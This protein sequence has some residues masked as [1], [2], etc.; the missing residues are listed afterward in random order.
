MIDATIRWSLYIAS[1]V[2][3]GPLAGLLMDLTDGPDGSAGTVLVSASPV[4]GALS[5]LLGSLLAA[6]IG[7]LAGW[8]SGFRP[9]LTCAGIVVCWMAGM[10][11]GITPAIAAADGGPWM[12]FIL[13]GVLVGACLLGMGVAVALAARHHTPAPG[14]HVTAQSS[15]AMRTELDLAFTPKTVATVVLGAAVG[16]G[17]AWVLA[18]TDL[19]GQV[20]AASAIAAVAVGVL[21]KLVD[22]RTPALAALAALALLG[23]AGPAYAMATISGDDALLAAY[24]QALP[25]IVR[26]TPLDWAAGALLGTPLGLAWAASIVKRA[27]HEPP[28][29]L[30]A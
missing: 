23:V 15:E 28:R 4:L 21:I 27:E 7:A 1:L 12:A 10:S 19:K 11:A 18:V 20:I 13:E 17:A 2:V 29:V 24:A 26:L 3:V 16:G 9:G 30:G 25:G 6:G 5:L 14:E 8:R 22:I